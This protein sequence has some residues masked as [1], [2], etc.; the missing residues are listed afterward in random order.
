MN[1]HDLKKEDVRM[2]SFHYLKITV[3]LAGDRIETF[4]FDS[5]DELEKALRLWATK[6]DAEKPELG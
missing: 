1:F 6:P 2:I 4:R 5:R 3:A